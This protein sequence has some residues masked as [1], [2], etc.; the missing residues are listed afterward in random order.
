MNYGGTPI[1][2]KNLDLTSRSL[3][4][5]QVMQTLFLNSTDAGATNEITLMSHI[6]S[7]ANLSLSI[8]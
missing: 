5:A 3:Y 7:Y 2:Y 6:V 8:P 1:L 4:N